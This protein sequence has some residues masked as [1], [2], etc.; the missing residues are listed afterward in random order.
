MSERRAP[1]P[2][3]RIGTLGAILWTL[4]FAV[5][6]AMVAHL[7]RTSS[8]AINAHLVREVPH[9]HFAA[10]DQGP[11]PGGGG[12]VDPTNQ[13]S[14]DQAMTAHHEH[15]PP[16]QPTIIPTGRPF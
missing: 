1:L 11:P 7:D 9:T 8:S 2:Q 13:N 15:S 5:M 12:L 6:F 10:K 3:G 4:P 16:P 14:V